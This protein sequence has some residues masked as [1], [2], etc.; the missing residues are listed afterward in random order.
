M[1][2]IHDPWKEL[3]FESERE[4]FKMVSSVDLS[5][6]ETLLKFI[7]WKTNDGTKIGLEKVNRGD[8]CQ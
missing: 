7:A 8:S 1:S 4:M 6:E 3:G 5:N 2:E